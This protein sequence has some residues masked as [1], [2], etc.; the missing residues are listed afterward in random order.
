MWVTHYA[1][2]GS[3]SNHSSYCGAFFVTTNYASSVA[4]WASGA[5]LSFKPFSTHYTVRGGNTAAGVYCGFSLVHFAVSPGITNW[6][7][8]AAL[9]IH[10]ILLAVDILNV[11]LLLEC[12][13]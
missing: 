5:A 6:H 8:S 3:Y 12:L 1:M 11:V 7:V 10:I 9:Y 13:F 2:R 4:T